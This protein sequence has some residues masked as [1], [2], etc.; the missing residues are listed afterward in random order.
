VRRWLAVALAGLGC[1]APAAS[2]S[3]PAHRVIDSTSTRL[4]II[5]GDDV[6]AGELAVNLDPDIYVVHPS[7]APKRVSYVTDRGRIDF[8]VKPGDSYDFA[9]RQGGRL[10]N[11]RVATDDRIRLPIRA[12]P[13]APAGSTSSRSVS[14]RTMRST[15]S[16]PSTEAG[17]WI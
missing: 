7:K 3:D 1:W 8:V 15:S 11:Q 6:L 13:H 17:R 2:A 16:A 4:K 5:D 14:A 12:L 10:Y 9:I